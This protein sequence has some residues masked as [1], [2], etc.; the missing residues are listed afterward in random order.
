[1]PS[2]QPIPASPEPVA[3]SCVTP[4]LA[5]RMA[6]F[7]YEG[8]MLFGVLM[9]GGYLFS[10][11]TQQRHALVGRHGLQAFL[12]L[13]LGIYF[14]WFWSRGGQ[15]V[16]MKA[17]HIRVLDSQGRP[18]TQWRAALRYLL[19]WTWFFPAL[20]WAW[21]A[22]LHSAAS[23]FVLL[24]VG[25]LTYAALSRLH[26]QRQFWHDAVCGTKLVTQAQIDTT[27]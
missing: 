4:G 7:T 2:P 6:C 9:V 17:W 15:T 3:Q 25:V 19:S 23:I 13:L 11:L 12:F 20:L 24:C 5:R 16:A 21:F 14:V 27:K 8:V 22:Q 10:S 1:M 26:P 18:L